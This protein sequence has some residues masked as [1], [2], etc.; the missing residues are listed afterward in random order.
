MTLRR[1]AAAAIS[2]F[3]LVGLLSTSVTPAQAT[4][5]TI[6]GKVSSSLRQYSTVRY[7]A[8]GMPI[9][10]SGRIVSTYLGGEQPGTTV[11]G[12]PS[13]WRWALGVVKSGTQYTRLEFGTTSGSGTFPG[14]SG[15]EGRY[16][17]NFT[18]N[19]RGERRRKED[20]GPSF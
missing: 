2:T 17:Y 19:R 15:Y 6:S 4:T 12:L 18:L 13:G 1:R 20:W 11:G 10:F 14:T 8:P 16:G 9:K 7:K 5:V 3:M